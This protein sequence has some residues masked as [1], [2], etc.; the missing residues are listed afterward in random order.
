MYDETQPNVSR[1]GDYRKIYFQITR[2]SGVNEV[3]PIL[4]DLLRATEA[5]R[6][7]SFP[8]LG[9]TFIF[10]WWL[11]EQPQLQEH[12]TLRYVLGKCLKSMPEV[13]VFEHNSIAIGVSIN[14]RRVS[15]YCVCLQVYII[16]GVL[17]V[18]ADN[19]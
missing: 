5:N 7:N 18:L 11:F 17:I 14:A 13:D 3:M 4:L 9:T 12:R 8:K 6:E 15:I 10:L 19:L 1:L 2:Q 16:L